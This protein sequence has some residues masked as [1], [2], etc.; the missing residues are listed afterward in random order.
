MLNAFTK[1]KRKNFFHPWNCLCFFLS[2]L[3]TGSSTDTKAEST[4]SRLRIK[5]PSITRLLRELLKKLTG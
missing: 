5:N 3:S 1:K 4:V 2:V